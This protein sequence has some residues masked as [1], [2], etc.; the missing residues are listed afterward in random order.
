MH[1]TTSPDNTQQGHISSDIDVVQVSHSL[2]VH[3][4]TWQV[5]INFF[6]V[7]PIYL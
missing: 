2:K 6:Q 5:V 3:Y 1:N 4:A 7:A